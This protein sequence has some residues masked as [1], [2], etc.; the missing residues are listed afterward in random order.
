M[1]NISATRKFITPKIIFV[2]LGVVILIEIIYAVRVLTSPAAS[3]PPTGA[4]QTGIQPSAGKI[5]LTAPKSDYAVGETISVA[6]IIDTGGRTING[7]DLIVRFDPKIL[8]ISS[9]GLIK[10]KILD[11][12]PGM[13]QDAK[14]G[15]ISIS[16]ISNSNG[17]SGS[18]QFATINLQAKVSGKTSLT[19][20]FQGRDFTIDSNLVETATS[21]DILEVVSNLELNIR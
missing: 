13:S 2:I 19:V 9:G 11:E 1:D 3:T 15:L 8:E 20:D 21:R 6:V 5:S 7:V 17:F 4:N 12:Y 10:G 14:A 18:G 16:G